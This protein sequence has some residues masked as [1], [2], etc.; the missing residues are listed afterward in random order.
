MW[1]R[2]AEIT[3]ARDG[4]SIRHDTVSGPE[5]RLRAALLRWDPSVKGEAGGALAGAAWEGPDGRIYWGWPDEAGRIGL[6]AAPDRPEVCSVLP[7]ALSLALAFRRSGA[8]MGGH[9]LVVGEGFLSRVARVVVLA[10]GCRV[11]APSG[12]NQGGSRVEQRPDIVIET[13][14]QPE[15]LEWAIERC[16][17]WG[18]VFSAG[19]A[20]TSAPLDYYPHV[21]Q[22]ALAVAHVPAHPMLHPG[23]EALADR[24]AEIL[25]ATLRG[26]SPSGDE[27]QGARILPEGTAGRLERERSGWGLLVVEG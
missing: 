15:N 25:A 5:C 1:L 13:T 16:R 22:R 27:V 8:E 26:L 24:T 20:L 14:G 10:A 6:R 18:M 21:H 19:G 12:R 4:W 23:E 17:D 9:A 7:P 11:S 3:F 2:T